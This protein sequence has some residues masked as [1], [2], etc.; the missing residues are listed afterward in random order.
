MASRMEMNSKAVREMTDRDDW[1][2]A[3]SK[4]EEVGI[5]WRNVHAL[6]FKLILFKTEAAVPGEPETNFVTVDAMVKFI[7]Y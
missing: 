6:S 3:S 5:L 1:T 2:S 7:T 4:L